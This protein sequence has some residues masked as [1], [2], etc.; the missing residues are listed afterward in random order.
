MT[1]DNNIEEYRNIMAEIF[2]NIYKVPNRYNP[3]CDELLTNSDTKLNKS[4]IN[5]SCKYVLKTKEDLDNE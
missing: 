2:R 3:F 1:E 5:E 4:S